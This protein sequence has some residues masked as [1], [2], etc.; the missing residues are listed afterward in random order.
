[1]D[2][3]KAMV[4]GAILM[5]AMAVGIP[6]GIRVI[7]QRKAQAAQGQ[8]VDLKKKFDVSLENATR[9][10]EERRAL[11]TDEERQMLAGVL[12]SVK[13]EMSMFGGVLEDA[14]Q[15]YWAGKY[16]EAR[17]ASEAI[18][19][20]ISSANEKVVGVINFCEQKAELRNAVV[21][22]EL[23][24]KARLK[25]PYDFTT[26]A[27]L[28]EELAMIPKG[29]LSHV[30]QASEEFA[31]QLEILELGP[32][33]N[34]SMGAALVAH[35]SLLSHI[36]GA[37]MRKEIKA[38]ACTLFDEARTSYGKVRARNDELPKWYRPSDDGTFT[39][40]MYADLKQKQDEVVALIAQGD[41][42]LKK[43]DEYY[44]FLHQ[45]ECVY[46]W[47]HAYRRKQFSHTGLR[48][49]IDAD[50]NVGVETY[51]YWTDGREFFCVVRTA[52][53]NGMTESMVRVGEI[54][55]PVALW[56]WSPEQ[57]IGYVQHWKP[58][59]DDLVYTGKL[60]NL[61]PQIV[62]ER[63]NLDHDPFEKK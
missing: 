30:P 48:S 23:Y 41:A 34:N 15:K 1:M 46:V 58:L 16:D 20:R 19:K 3:K 24:L 6:C 36:V 9:S 18:E 56:A 59:H 42:R 35:R 37:A 7:K 32:E 14:S 54:D 43:L 5:I 17:A 2:S 21:Q 44:A 10:L 4:L 45:Q 51:E 62:E 40:V 8:A 63:P 13:E 11:L 12:A 50:G 26:G 57:A 33:Y 61:K 38:R 47:G 60:E 55:D 31:K 39:P 29:F 53:V 52:T 28:P 49:T 27:E 25:K 22:N